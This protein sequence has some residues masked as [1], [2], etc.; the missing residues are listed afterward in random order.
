M[1]LKVDLLKEKVGFDD[2][3]NYKDEANLNS[4]LQRCFPKGIDIYFDNVGGEMLEEVVKNMNTCGRIEACG[5]I[6]EYTNPQKRAKLDMCSI[7][8]QAK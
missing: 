4:T 7:F 2:A 6:S 1:Y 8:G 5:A 3:F